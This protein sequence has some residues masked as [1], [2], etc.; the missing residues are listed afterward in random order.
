MRT[1]AFRAMTKVP[2]FRRFYVRRILRFIEKSKAKGRPLPADLVR[3]DQMTAKLPKK[4][5]EKLLEEAMLTSQTDEIQSRELRR[6]SRI[7]SVAVVGAGA[8][9]RPRPAAGPC[10][11]AEGGLGAQRSRHQVA[12]TTLA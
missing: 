6:P 12:A 4:K 11:G 7:A 3:V 2:L 5:K 10:S 8:P 9:A 1:V